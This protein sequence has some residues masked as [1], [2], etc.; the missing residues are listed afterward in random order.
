M[1]KSWLM[2]VLLG[3]LAWGQAFPGA[4]T[5]PQPAQAPVDTSASVLPDAAVITVVGVCPA[6][7]KTAAAKGTA[8]KPVTAA[9]A[10]AAKTPAAD[11]KTVITKAQFEKLIGNLTPNVTPQAKKQLANLLPRLIAM[12]NEAKQ[13]GMDKTPQFKDRAKF[14]EMQILAEALQQ[15]VQDEAAKIPPEEIEKYYKEHAETFEQFNVDRLYVPRTK[16]G[17]AEAKEDDENAEKATEET[18]K[19]KEAEEK[20]KADEAEQ[21][22]TKLAESLRVRAAAGEDFVKLQKEA[23]DAAGM[24][25]ESPNVNLA[26]LRRTGLAQG[27]AAVF[28]LKPGEVSQVISDA[29]GHYI[30]KLNSKAQLPLDQATNE[31]HGK[32]Q[33]ERTREMME[34]MNSSFKVE[35]N[36]QYFGPGGVG[37]APP[38]RL[39]RPRPVPP[40][41][42]STQPGPGGVGAAPPPPAKPN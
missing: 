12:S 14:R 31:I 39:P 29:G 10:P 36:E 11:C 30:Y 18:K 23:S 17:E 1:R 27:H 32:L 15:S 13:K 34:K 22:M 8:A 20:A 4:P 16:Q 2:C 25:I 21:S 24:K 3:T 7:P 37:A 38:P 9:K 28:D 40:M 5:P 19:A 6:Q 33:N 41:P 35:T 26:N 42:Q